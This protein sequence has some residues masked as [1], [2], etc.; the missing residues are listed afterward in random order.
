[1]ALSDYSDALW[2]FLVTVTK[3]P[4]VLLLYSSLLCLSYPMDFFRIGAAMGDPFAPWS[5][6]ASR[7]SSLSRRSMSMGK[8]AWY[9]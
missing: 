3:S 1:M 2:S 7:L 9:F 4:K 8:M 6:M 5:A